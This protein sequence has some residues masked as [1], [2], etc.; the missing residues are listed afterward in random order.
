MPK[1]FLLNTHLE[2]KDLL[3]YFQQFLENRTE[4]MR[5]Y[6]NHCMKNDGDTEETSQRICILNAINELEACICGTT[7]D[8]LKISEDD[9]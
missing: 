4:D 5:E 9:D 1:S 7:L 3:D 2:E 6:V 8:D